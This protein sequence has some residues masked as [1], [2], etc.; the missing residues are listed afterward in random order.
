M[1]EALNV[2]LLIGWSFA[3]FQKCRWN[4]SIDGVWR[5]YFIC[6]FVFFFSNKKKSTFTIELVVVFSNINFSRFFFFFLKF[7]I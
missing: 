1:I 5:W 4:V 7:M 6:F 2:F 3:F